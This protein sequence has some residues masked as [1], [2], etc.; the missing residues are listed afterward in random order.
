MATK[1]AILHPPNETENSVSRV[2]REGKMITYTLTVIQQ[3]ERARACGAGAKSAADRRPV[4]PPPVVQL[5]I[6][7]SD[8][9]DQH[10]TD[11]TFGYNANFFL[12]ATLEW[13][14]PIAHGR[15]QT[16]TPTCAALTGVPVAGI[17]YLDRPHQAGYF[18]F[19]DLSVRHEGLYR[20]NFNLYE[21]MKNPKDASKGAPM[22]QPQGYLAAPNPSKLRSPNQFLDFRL[23]VKSIP[24]TVYSA[25]K[26]PGLAE[27]TS[28]SRIVAEQGC[29]VRIRR[30]V[31]MRRRE[32]KTNKA[33]GGY[34]DRHM[35]PDPYP[36]T[37]VERPHS[38]SHASVD[39]HYRYSAGPSR[40]QPSPE[41]GYH[42]SSYKHHSP[43][44]T[45]PPPHLYFA[46]GTDQTLYHGPPPP[47][48]AHQAPPPQAPFPSPH[49]GYAHTRQVSAGSPEYD[50]QQPKYTPYSPST[51][52]TDVYDQRKPNIPLTPSI[53][54]P[55][56]PP[57]M[58]YEQRVADPKLYIPSTQLHAA[59]PPSLPS[60]S[61]TRPTPVTMSPTTLNP[62][63]VE[64]DTSVILPAP[65][66]EKVS[67]TSVPP[68]GRLLF[69][70][71][72]G[73]SKRTRDSSDQ[74]EPLRNGQRPA[75][76]DDKLGEFG[77][78]SGSDDEL[79]KYRRADGRMMAKQRVLMYCNGKPVHALQSLQL[80]PHG[81]ELLSRGPE[82]CAVVE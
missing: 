21:E 54:T 10:K 23:V 2:T 56:N 26:F 41:Y 4:D 81:P 12:F 71:K 57:P 68:D 27:S 30:D 63:S 37:P 8:L 74:D 29:R 36:G 60:P 24:F 77:E 80:L 14:R 9:N 65:E 22:I 3:P 13:A 70:N 32:P 7:E 18:I 47:T 78:T 16:Q 46:F 35:T 61:Q 53:D 6:Y 75:S 50:S 5:R 51:P 59:P 45:A 73:P 48:A 62:I 66:P 79:M 43:V 72:S 44:S 34:D 40:V 69:A 33:Y 55:S 28:L 82:L 39:D 17:S 1:S 15:V 49:L 64:M 67:Y 19:P 25:K 58:P 52:H 76:S 42:P 31:R 20:L 11:I 38:T